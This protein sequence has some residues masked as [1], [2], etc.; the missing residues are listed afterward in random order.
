[1]SVKPPGISFRCSLAAIKARRVGTSSAGVVRP[2]NRMLVDPDA[3]RVDTSI[4]NIA[5]VVFHFV[6]F[7]EVQILIFK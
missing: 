4:P 6:L 7:Q 2:R 5:W 1:M 3:R